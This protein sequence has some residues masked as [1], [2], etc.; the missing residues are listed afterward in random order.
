[1]TKV[2]FINPNTREH[3]GVL[4]TVFPPQGILSISAVLLQAGYD[5]KVTDA[6]IDNLSLDDVQSIISEYRPDIVGITMTTLQYKSAMDTAEHIKRHNRDILIVSGGCHPSAMKGALLERNSPIDVLVIGEGEYTFLELVKAYEE[7]SSFQN[8]EGTCI[9]IG[10]HIIE[11]PPRRAIDNLDELPFPALHLV[12]PINRYPGAYPI[13]AQPSMHIMA[14]RG[15]PFHC[16]FCSDPIWGKKVR[17][18]SPNYVL[19]EVEWLQREFGVHEI[20]FQ[21]D[22][23]NLNRNWF[24]SICNG[25]IDRGLNK[26]CIFKAPFRANKNLVDVDLLKLARRAGFW[27]FFF[28]VE[29]GNQKILD[30]IKKNL[31]LSEI[32]RAFKLTKRVGIKTYAS[33][34]VGNLGETKATVQDTISFAKRIDPD[35]YGFAVATPYPSSELYASAER[36]GLLKATFGEYR[37][38]EYILRSNEFAD[39]EVEKLAYFAQKSVEKYKESSLYKLKKSLTLYLDRLMLNGI[40]PPQKTDES[41]SCL[42]PEEIS[43]QRLGKSHV[44]VEI[45]PSSAK[46]AMRSGKE[47]DLKISIKNIG[48]ESFVSLSPYPVYLSYHWR[49]NNNN[50]IIFDGARTPIMPALKPEETRAVRMTVIAPEKPGEYVLDVTLVQEMCFWFEEMLPDLPVSIPCNVT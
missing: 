47:M 12:A 5:V 4:L 11:N 21:D 8:V 6:D 40:R 13:G 32:A 20:F 46:P 2:L 18:K 23:F 42:F 17:F 27:M 45:T 43:M 29:S 3:H 48:K 26:N 28:G 25:I 1:M 14:S 35:F 44:G 9:R 19:S 39:G 30:S 34:M 10:Q 16:S 37:F 15:C 31:K 50:I 41:L 49:D 38:N 22:T 7:K 24:E 36:G 33:F